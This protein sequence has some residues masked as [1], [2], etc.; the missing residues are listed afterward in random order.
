MNSSG[1]QLLHVG[2]TT[3]NALNDGSVSVTAIE[4][5]SHP[6]FVRDTFAY[7]FVVLKLSGWVSIA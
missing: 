4:R 3:R 5:V 7:D 1:G 2:T 6:D